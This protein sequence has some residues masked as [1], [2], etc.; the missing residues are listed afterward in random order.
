MDYTKARSH[1]EATVAGKPGWRGRPVNFLQLLC[2][3]GTQGESV[4]AQRHVVDRHTESPTRAH[5]H[6]HTLSLSLFLLYKQ[7]CRWRVGSRSIFRSPYTSHSL[8]LLSGILVL[9]FLNVAQIYWSTLSLLV[10]LP[11]DFLLRSD[12]YN[13]YLTSL[14]DSPAFLL[15]LEHH[16][17]PPKDKRKRIPSTH[18]LSTL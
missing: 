8:M 17:T 4:E 12:H 15:V 1:W 16:R 2:Y 14:L 9:F 7:R 13:F 6:A 18:S 11:G 10:L 5:T 3:G